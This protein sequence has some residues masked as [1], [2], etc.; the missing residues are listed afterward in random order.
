MGTRYTAIS[1]A[2]RAIGL[3]AYKRFL[4]L[5]SFQKGAGNQRAVQMVSRCIVSRH[6]GVK[7][8]VVYGI[9]V[10]FK[11]PAE[12][13]TSARKKNQA[14]KQPL[15]Q[16][17]KGRE[18][19]HPRSSVRHARTGSAGFI[20][21]AGKRQHQPFGRRHFNPMACYQ[22]RPPADAASGG[23]I[24]DEILAG[25]DAAFHMGVFFSNMP[26]GLLRVMAVS[27]ALEAAAGCFDGP[28]QMLDFRFHTGM[29]RAGIKYD[30]QCKA[31]GG[32]CIQQAVN[33]RERLHLPI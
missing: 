8:D 14:K 9:L 27:V 2:D 29:G 3:E 18:R 31:D 32:Q 26:A 25:C 20:P 21:E 1:W 30:G 11:Y 22:I 5:Q 15:A 16:G 12:F 10:G 24:T 17:R 19:E 33:R 6:D 4:S 28:K 23:G 13:I 7:A